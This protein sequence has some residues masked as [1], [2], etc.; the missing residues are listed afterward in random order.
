[1]SYDGRRRRN[2]RA[3]ER[4]VTTIRAARFPG[5]AGSVVETLTFT[6]KP[7]SSPPHTAAG[8]RNLSVRN[9][10]GD[11]LP[12]RVENAHTRRVVEPVIEGYLRRWHSD[13]YYILEAAPTEIRSWKA[14]ATQDAREHAWKFARAIAEVEAE[15]EKRHP[16]VVLT[17]HV[18]PEDEPVDT[19][20]QAADRDKSKDYRD[21]YRKIVEEL[22]ELE[23]EGY[24][25]M[26]ADTEVSKRLHT[27]GEKHSIPRI[28]K[29][30]EFVKNERRGEV[31]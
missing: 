23:L 19:K 25:K 15:L 12:E 30:R 26:A 2:L 8:E 31:A 4:Y 24:S 28:R 9:D 13:S 1:M 29:A 7:E 21:S 10:N 14:G 18:N 22:E 27:R 11:E 17:V 6:G 5:T 16:G 3:I 20:R